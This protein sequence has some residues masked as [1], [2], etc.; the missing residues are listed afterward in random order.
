MQWRCCGP[1]PS[2]V[3]CLGFLKTAKQIGLR[4]P[5]KVLARPDPV[6]K[7]PPGDARIELN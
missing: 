3:Y 1:F 6:I 5:Q 7:G 2:L 4:I